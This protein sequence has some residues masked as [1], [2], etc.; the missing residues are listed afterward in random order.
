MRNLVN[1]RDVEIEVESMDQKGTA[2]G[3]MWI[4]KGGQRRNVGV[5]LLTRGFGQL[6]KPAAE[7]SK[8]VATWLLIWPGMDDEHYGRACIRR[9]L[10]HSRCDLSWLS[11]LLPV[12]CGGRCGNSVVVPCCSCACIRCSLWHSRCDGWCLS[13]LFP[14]ACGRRCGNSVVVPC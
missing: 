12:A 7:K 1:Q 2:V 3:G 13:L 8:C 9:P 4:G 10:W 14:V 5:E 6:F 11:L